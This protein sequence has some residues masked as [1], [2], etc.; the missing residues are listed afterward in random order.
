MTPRRNRMEVLC[1]AQP[2][3]RGGDGAAMLDNKALADLV[4]ET[5]R[6]VDEGELNPPAAGGV[7]GAFQPRVMLAMLTY[8]YVIGVCGSWDVES[9]MRED[10]SLR[11]LC[12]PDIPDWKM[13]K[14]FRRWN[15]PMIQRALE[16]TFR[17]AW[18]LSCRAAQPAGAP[19]GGR[20]A[21]ASTGLADPAMADWI[22]AEATARIE[23]AMFID[24]MTDD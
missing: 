9:M 11:A 13:L 21:E 14:R 19:C 15:R 24:Q 5:V 18:S 3:P 7:V 2:G 1:G 4:L 6:F 17:G 10:A 16:E 8:C 20:P 22:A 23:R 12:G